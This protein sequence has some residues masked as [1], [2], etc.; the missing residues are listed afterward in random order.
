MGSGPVT[1]EG[2]HGH[3]LQDAM[4]NNNR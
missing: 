4:K 3:Q 1:G 2:I